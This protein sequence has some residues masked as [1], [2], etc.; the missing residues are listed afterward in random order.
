M[1]KSWMRF[2]ALRRAGVPKE[3][4]SRVLEPGSFV[5]DA[6]WERSEELRTDRLGPSV[7]DIEDPERV[8]VERWRPQRGLGPLPRR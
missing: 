5:M 4:A 6:Q 1:K 8:R 2:L 3:K 7:D